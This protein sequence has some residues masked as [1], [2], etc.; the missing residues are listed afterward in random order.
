MHAPAPQRRTPPPRTRHMPPDD[1]A[2]RMQP[3]RPRRT[4][5]RAQRPRPPHARHELARPHRV[6]S[7]GTTLR[8]FTGA[9]AMGSLVLSLVLIGVQ[10]WATG[11][12][13]QGPGVG[14]VV[15]QVVAALVAVALQTYADRH[16]DRNGGLAVAGVLI[17]VLG[18]LWFWWW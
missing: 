1:G 6:S 8:S 14:A 9:L 17:V 16:R 10:F 3:P 12:G 7:A 2:R 15:S 13:Q 18:S 4:A 11:H 5:P